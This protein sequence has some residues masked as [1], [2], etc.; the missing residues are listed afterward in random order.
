MLQSHIDRKARRCNIL[1]GNSSVRKE[2]IVNKVTWLILKI[3]KRA[4]VYIKLLLSVRFFMKWKL[5][6][7]YFLVSLHISFHWLVIGMNFF[8]HNIMTLLH[9]MAFV[10][11][12][13]TWFVLLYASNLECWFSC[14]LGELPRTNEFTYRNISFSRFK[15]QIMKSISKEY[16]NEMN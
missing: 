10:I 2:N 4:R 9:W 5:C 1:P 3:L 13:S 7:S 14:G 11:N 12:D 6:L 16:V 15:I 8:V